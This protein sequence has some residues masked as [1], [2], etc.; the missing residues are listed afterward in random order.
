MADRQ[1]AI[2]I[3]VELERRGKL[4]PRQKEMLGELRSRVASIP[5]PAGMPSIQGPVSGARRSFLQGAML[6]YSD[7]ALAAAKSALGMG[8]YKDLLSLE[9]QRLK[10][11]P[12]STRIPAEI[13]GGALTTAAATPYAAATRLGGLVS[14]LPSMARL[15][16]VGALEGAIA[17]A[18][19]TEGGLMSRGLGA[20]GGAGLGSVT[21]AATPMLTAPVRA[22]G[23]ALGGLMGLVPPRQTRQALGRVAQ[24]FARDEMAPQQFVQRAGRLPA[25]APV[26]AA[27][28]ENL[29]GLARA[30]SQRP[31]PAKT[32]VERTMRR[33]A[34]GQIPRLY[35][36]TRKVTGGQN[37]GDTLDQII[38]N[39]RTA[40]APLYDQAFNEVPILTSDK[41][42]DLAD[43]PIVKS[44]MKEAR[45]VVRRAD[46]GTVTS[47][48]DLPDNSIELWDQVYKIIGDKAHTARSVAKPKP[49][50]AFNLEQLR[51]AVREAITEQSPTYGQALDV[52]SDQSRLKDA[53]TLGRDVLSPK[54]PS[55]ETIQKLPA[56]EREMFVVGVGQAIEDTLE[57]IGDVTSM[58]NAV[59]KIFNNRRTRDRLAAG[60]PSLQSYQQFKQGILAEQIMLK[61]RR[62]VTPS[63]GSPTAARLLEDAD[64]QSPAS[65]HGI[66]QDVKTA[67]VFGT[68]A[69]I[70]SRGAR[71]LESIGNRMKAGP[72]GSH[73]ETARLL[74]QPASQAGQLMADINQQLLAEEIYRLA[75]AG[76]MGGATIAGAREA[77]SL[78]TDVLLP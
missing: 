31:G 17:G 28:K 63:L 75:Q 4:N 16:T 5:E 43:N 14:S 76:L 69:A 27:G 36:L 7:E 42:T 29:M 3:L 8:E 33:S 19:A 61:A 53:L 74:M 24:N 6:N 65:L 64:V 37:F 59:E 55:P 44:A 41:L 56:A 18:G 57:T 34:A 15:G 50:R 49:N 67:N 71:I 46:D 60:L 1:R 45:K 25:D 72:E 52:F 39:R 32:L 22:G 13:A 10:D 77:P 58:R 9:R 23:R 30:V 66:L 47:F 54:G 62:A 2:N 78:M 40:A 12:A 11:V 48:K 21:G 68:P 20:V 26:V 70:R 51:T 35:A 73:A 38:Q